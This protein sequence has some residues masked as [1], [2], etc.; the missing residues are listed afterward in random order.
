[1]GPEDELKRL[2][3]SHGLDVRVA[4]QA[5][6]RFI[7]VAWGDCACSLYT[8][9]EGRDRAVGFVRALRESGVEVELLL[10]QD[11]ETLGGLAA[12]PALLTWE[13]FSVSG[14]QALPEARVTRLSRQ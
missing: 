7:E 10:F 14:L 13:E 5:E 6:T 12:T 3:V 1:V 4:T 9:A 2:A 11:G 8:K